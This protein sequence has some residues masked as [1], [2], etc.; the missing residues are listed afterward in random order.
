VDSSAVV[1][2][3]ARQGGRVKTFS[4]GFDVKEYDETEFA[5]EVAQLY[6][7]DHEEL[8]VEPKAME[9]LPR[10]V[11]HYG[12]PFADSSAIPT[13]YLA[14]LTRRHVTVALNGDGGDENFAGYG[15]YVAA[16][17]AGRLSRLP[18]AAKQ[19]LARVA[20]AVG[21]DSR[22]DSLRARAHRVTRAA[23]DPAGSQYLDSALFGEAERASLYTP[24]FLAALGEPLARTVVEQPYLASDAEDEVNRLL[25]LDV[26][27]YLTDELLVKVDIASMAH[28]LEVRSPLLDHRFMTVAASLPG[29][30]KVDGR[31]TKK[32]FK[33]ALVPWL[34]QHILER[35]KRGFG[36]PLAEWFQ[37]ELKELPSEILLDRQSVGRGFFRA[38]AVRQL[39]TDHVS[40]TRDNSARIWALMQL[41]LWLRT[42][43]DRRED[44]PIALSV[45]E[46]VRGEGNFARH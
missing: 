2:A 45:A 5:R 4:I 31:R 12:E 8:S 44:G 13:F 15:R 22:P 41:E 39:I 37:R 36:A 14:E 21:P 1:A 11:W 27:T 7:T 10:L 32:I 30:W 29:S 34:P 42:F 24:E 9:V 26:Q 16:S 46:S 28:S 35:R 38:E 18:K 20:S 6:D 25:D 33:D 3:M 17:L 23:V 19:V 43:V 40:G